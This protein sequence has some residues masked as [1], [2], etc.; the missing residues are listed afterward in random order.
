VSLPEGWE[1]ATLGD[2]A[3]YINGRG[4]KKTEWR[5]EGI[6]IIRIQNLNNEKAM[7]NYADDTF[8]EKYRVKN[9][10]LLVSWSASLGAYIW[11]GDDAW[12]NQHIF[13]VEPFSI[14]DNQFLYYAVTESIN[15]LYQKSHG[16][17]MVHI[18]KGTFESHEIPLPPLNQ[19]KQISQKLD[20]ALARVERIKMAFDSTPATIKRFRQSVLALATSGGLS[21][22]K[23]WENLTIDDI[24]ENIRYGTSKKCSYDDSLTPVLR[25]P[26]IKDNGIDITDIKSANFNEKEFEALA[27]KIGDILVIRSNGSIDLVGKN[28]VVTEEHE[29]YI[30][31]GYLIRVRLNLTLANP[32]YIHYVL[33][34]P[35][36]RAVINLTAKSTSGINNLNSKEIGRLEVSLP[37]LEEQKAIVKKVETLFALADNLEAKVNQAQKQVDRLT[38]SILA[39]AFRGEL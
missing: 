5:T 15:E 31:A 1:I 18:N 14:V 39:K 27:L 38:Q 24:L 9:G 16:M 37:P 12:L 29:D 21:E 3:K 26:N 19:Q 25:I 35:Q 23:G 7:F 32:K 6:P 33:S 36:T 17:G 22:G 4:F 2:L 20:Q 10:D 30:F 28:V 8:D 11:K 34:S 13:K